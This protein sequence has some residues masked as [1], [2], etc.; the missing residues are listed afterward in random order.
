M[1]I[2][3]INYYFNEGVI[4]F[5]ENNAVPADH[6]VTLVQRGTFPYPEYLTVYPKQGTCLCVLVGARFKSENTGFWTRTA[7]EVTSSKA[8]ISFAT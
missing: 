7:A 3:I 6:S 1:L 2:I 8:A 4:L 5:K